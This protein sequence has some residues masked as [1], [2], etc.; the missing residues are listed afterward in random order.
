MADL[1][2]EDERIS[3]TPI[4][5]YMEYINLQYARY[6][7]ENFKEITSGDSTYLIN[8]FYHQNISQRELADLLFV[9]ESNVA[10]IIKKLENKGFIERL[11]DENNKCRKNLRLTNIGKLTVFS[12]IKVI[13]EGESKLNESYSQEEIELFKKMLYDY[14]NLAIADI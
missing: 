7:R 10:Q 2:F 1:N 11:V 6:L 4:I 9:S 8:I 14:S 5:L 12:L 3:F 13:Y